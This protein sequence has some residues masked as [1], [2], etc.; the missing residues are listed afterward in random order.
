MSTQF[1]KLFFTGA[2]IT[3]AGGFNR[4]VEDADG[5]PYIAGLTFSND[6]PTANAFQ[7]L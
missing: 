5:N 2:R 4:A 1:R 3:A 7:P 6:L